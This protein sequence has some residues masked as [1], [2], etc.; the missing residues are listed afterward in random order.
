MQARGSGTEI[1]ARTAS[2]WRSAVGYQLL[3]RVLSLGD[4]RL[5]GVELLETPRADQG[6]PGPRLVGT[7]RSRSAASRLAHVARGVREPRGGHTSVPGNRASR[8]RAQGHVHNGK[9][10]V[11]GARD[12]KCSRDLPPRPLLLPKNAWVRRL[13]ARTRALGAA[14]APSRSRTSLERAA[15]TPYLTWRSAGDPRMSVVG[16]L[17]PLRG[18]ASSRRRRDPRVCRVHYQPRRLFPLALPAP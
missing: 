13:A 14:E 8:P 4:E 15:G 17:L 18:G 6:E 9:D 7:S 11:E 2:C 10:G 5:P 3:R 1:A 16:C 12:R